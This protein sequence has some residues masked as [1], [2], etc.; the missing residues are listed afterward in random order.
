MRMTVVLDD[1]IACG[2]T[3]SAIT[4][5]LES[6]APRDSQPCIGW[7]AAGITTSGL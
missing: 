5:W 7:A 6:L 4:G 1:D 2:A 3:L